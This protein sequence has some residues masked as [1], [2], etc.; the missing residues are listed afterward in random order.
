[1][2]TLSI[3]SNE[4]VLVPD[5]LSSRV[6]SLPLHIFLLNFMQSRLSEICFM[7]IL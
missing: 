6:E 7:E 5:K 4:K 1:M 3:A 2:T